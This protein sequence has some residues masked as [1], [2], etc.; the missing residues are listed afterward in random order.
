[1]TARSVVRVVLAIFFVIA[2]ANHF[3]DPALY[4][5]M[6]PP[7]VPSPDLLQRIAGAAEIAGGIGL[8]LP[9]LRRAAGWGLIALMVAVFPA[10]LYV[11]QVG[12]LGDLEMPPWALWIRL[13]FQLAFIGALVWV[14]LTPK[15]A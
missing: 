10:N 4:L 7:W 9:S 6:M 2:G 14:A 15:K 11:A 13:P 3:R 8:L 5:A 12:H 1:M